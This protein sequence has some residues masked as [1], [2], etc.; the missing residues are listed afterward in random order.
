M[1]RKVRTEDA[2]A[3]A[4]IYNHYILTTTAT[5]ETEP[6]PAEEMQMR[7]ADISAHGPYF[8]HESDGAVDGYCS[9]SGS[10]TYFKRE[11]HTTY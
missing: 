6:L 11:P 9:R 3:L 1:I 2:A 7:I 8:V 10:A 4:E 5:F